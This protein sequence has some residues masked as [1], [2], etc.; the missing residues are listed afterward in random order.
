MFEWLAKR[1]GVDVSKIQ[2]VNTATPGLIGFALADRADAVQLWEPAYTIL[3]SQEA[4]D[5]HAG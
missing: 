3:I 2:V 1:Q 5:P 4:L